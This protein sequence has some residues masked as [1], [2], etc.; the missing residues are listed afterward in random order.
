M[1]AVAKALLRNIA[2][3]DN[4]ASTSRVVDVFLEPFM[5]FLVG[6]FEISGKRVGDECVRNGF[7]VV[8]LDCARG[9]QWLSCYVQNIKQGLGKV[10]DCCIE[11]KNRRTQGI[12][13]GRAT[14]G[15]CG[16]VGATIL[17]YMTANNMTNNTREHD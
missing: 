13:T 4:A 17:G 7:T 12:Y 2:G 3:L 8:D 5:T 6:I 11:S 9:E 15:I 16:F 1:L 14:L 10:I